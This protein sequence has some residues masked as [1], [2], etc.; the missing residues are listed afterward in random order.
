MLYIIEQYEQEIT[1]KLLSDDEIADGYFFKFNVASIMRADMLTQIQALTT[2]IQNFLYKP[3]EA[4]EFLDLPTD[5]YGDVLVGN[6]AT[7]PLSLVGTQWSG[8][9]DNNG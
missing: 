4:R 2:A 5:P 8:G 7:I 3:N 6:G 9:G 1:Y